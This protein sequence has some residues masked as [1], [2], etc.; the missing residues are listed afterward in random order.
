MVCGY[1]RIEQG[2]ELKTILTGHARSGTMSI[3]TFLQQ[4]DVEARWQAG[5]L[6]GDWTGFYNLDVPRKDIMKYVHIKGDSLWTFESNWA[7]SFFMHSIQKYMDSSIR[8]LVMTRNPVDS[9]NSMLQYWSRKL[10]SDG[11]T[12][13]D[14]ARKYDEVYTSIVWQ[15]L[16]MQPKPRWMAFEKFI[17][18]EYTEKL[19]EMFDIPKTDGNFEKA[20]TQLE[21]KVN[22]AGEYEK[23]EHTEKYKHLHCAL[24][25]C[26][27]M[28][29]ILENVCDEI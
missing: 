27:W 5:P 19:F 25:K 17:D 26:Q 11:Y 13:D 8:F 28:K 3:A 4:F 24:D 9:C 15:A 22:T 18:G 16:N 12:I 2:G 20:A 21:K 29:N 23:I 7:L 14:C 6:A 1:K 10:R